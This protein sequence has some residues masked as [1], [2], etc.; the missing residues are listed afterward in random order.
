MQPSFVTGVVRPP[1]AAGAH[2]KEIQDLCGRV[3]L[4]TTLNVY[5][6]RFESLQ[7]RLAERLNETFRAARASEAA[8]FGVVDASAFDSGDEREQTGLAI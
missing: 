5:G 3:S 2:P 8:P 6:H 1:V 4:A 7:Q